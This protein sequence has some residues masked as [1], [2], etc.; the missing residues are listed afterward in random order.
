MPL[1]GGKEKIVIAKRLSAFAFA[2]SVAHFTARWVS[3]SMRSACGKAA[4][5][6]EPQ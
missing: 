2:L 6:A 3:F 4:L 5:T 1:S